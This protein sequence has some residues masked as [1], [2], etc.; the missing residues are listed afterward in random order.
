MHPR[1][2]SSLRVGRS[3]LELLTK[4]RAGES[5]PADDGAGEAEESSVDVVADLP[6]DPQSAEPVQQGDGL[7]DDPAVHAQP[8]AMFRAALGYDGCDPGLPYLLA[9]LVV[10]IAAVGVDLVRAPE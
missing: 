10:V 1:G 4:L 7:F 2:L 8:G 9:V 5:A 6:A 3:A